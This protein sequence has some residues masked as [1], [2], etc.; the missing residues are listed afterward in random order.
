MQLNHREE[1]FDP[2]IAAAGGRRLRIAHTVSF[3][4]DMSWEEL[5]WLV[6]GHEVHVCDE[7]LR[8]DAE[9]LVAYCDAHRD[10]RRQRDPDL[11]AAAV[12]GG[13]ARRPST[14]R[15]WCCSAARPCPTR[16][17]AGCATPTA[18]Y[19]YNL[20]GPTEYTINTLGGGTADSADPDGRHGRSGTPAA[21]CSTPWLRPVPP[22]VPGE[23]YVAGA[24]WPAATSAGPG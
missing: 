6:E 14:G 15:R 8:R 22:G 1:I 9:A 20:Y 19:G 21:T 23:L 10:R 17:G 13:P 16:C 24:G 7:E 11:R 12:R 4:F 18:R 3:A 5:L 2:A